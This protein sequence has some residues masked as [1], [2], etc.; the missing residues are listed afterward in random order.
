MVNLHA[1]RT[2]RERAK[3]GGGP[4]EKELGGPAAPPHPPAGLT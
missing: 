4:M 3:E 1:R 2:N